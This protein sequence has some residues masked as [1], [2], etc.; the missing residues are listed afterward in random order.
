MASAIEKILQLASSNLFDNASVSTCLTAVTDLSNNLDTRVNSLIDNAPGAL[1]TLNELAAALGDDANYATTV[2]NSLSTK[3]NLNGA[4]FTGDISGVNAKFMDVSGVNFFTTGGNFIGELVGNVTGNVTGNVQGSLTTGGTVIAGTY[5]IGSV[6]IISGSRQINN[7]ISLNVGN[8]N[9]PTEFAVDNN[10]NTSM[11]GILS[12]NTINEKTSAN[13]VTVDGVILK[14]SGIIISGDL[15]ANDASFNI[16]DIHTLKL[17][18]GLDDSE[19]KEDYIKT[20][21][22]DGVTLEFFDNT[23]L[24]I[25]DSGITDVKLSTITTSGKVNGSAITGDISANDASFNRVDIHTLN[26]TTGLGPGDLEEDYI[27]TNEVDNSTIEFTSDTLNV[28]NLGITN[29]KLANLCVDD[30]KLAGNISDVKLSTIT[31][32]G[33]VNGSAITGD[34]SA[35]DVK[36]NDVSGVNFFGGNFFGNLQGNAATVV[37]GPHT[38]I[39]GVGT[40]T[41]SP[42]NDRAL[43]VSGNIKLEKSGMVDTFVE[44]ISNNKKGY[45]LNND[46]TLKLHTNIS[47][48]NL[49]LQ[50]T[51]GNVGIGITNP[52][53]Q[54]EVDTQI[55]VSGNTAV[56]KILLENPAGT[57][58]YRILANVSDNDDYGFSITG[59]HTGSV[60]GYYQYNNKT[61]GEVQHE[62]LQPGIVLMKH[63]TAT[64]GG[65][66]ILDR[67]DNYWSYFRSSHHWDTF[68]SSL[69]YNSSPN[70]TT[71][72]LNWYSDGN[73][74][75]CNG[76]G[77]FVNASDNRLKHN[78]KE[79]NNACEIINKL[80]VLKY[81][82]TSK[83]YDE[84]HHFE[85]D[86]S[87]NP[88]TDEK[89][90]IETGFIAQEVEKIPELKY[91]VHKGYIDKLKTFK[92]DASGNEVLDENGEKILEKEEDGEEYSYSLNYQDIFC[93]NV[94]ATQELY[95]KNKLLEVKIVAS[96]AKITSLET[97]VANLLTRIAALENP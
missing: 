90:K 86:T 28:K 45:L 78:E 46:G 57:N 73:V 81:F 49:I 62:F 24:R 80:E 85:L 66:L 53:S 13:G 27:K 74:N 12:V 52:D 92:K 17:T 4:A 8:G 44:L 97:T 7:V 1:N 64:S 2:T 29:A 72:F 50:G 79:I 19:L 51:G 35:N 87:G 21:E 84:N 41:S 10:G 54:L 14:D 56:P 11:E 58:G 40:L 42:E 94:K 39:T 69:K 70:G 25:K 93:Y 38:N 59:T 67:G 77:S 96:E 5:N 18:T 75:V 16:V 82:K 60:G 30:S 76:G 71:M 33:K 48:N 55:K 32:A 15:S 34:I 37:V 3:A 9:D 43:D 6:G 95:E 31:T 89:Y 88:I 47:S 22:V 83:L 63:N 20:N 26:L 91:L 68:N 65:D 61:F 23:T 36:F